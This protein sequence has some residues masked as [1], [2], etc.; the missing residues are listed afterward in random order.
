MTVGYYDNLR[1]AAALNGTIPTVNP[2]DDFEGSVVGGTVLFGGGT[3][4]FKGGAW[5]WGNRGKYSSAWDLAK[6]NAVN[7]RTPELLRKQGNIFTNPFTNKYYWQK[8]NDFE[9]R[10]VNQPNMKADYYTNV[11][12]DLSN[13]KKL[14][15]EG[16]LHGKELKTALNGINDKIYQAELN[17]LNDIKNGTIKETGF[18]SKINKYT[19]MNAANR[20]CLKAATKE[21][22]TATAKATRVAG[23]VGRGLIK[24]GGPAC[25]AIEMAFETPELIETYSKLGA[26]KGT[27]QLAKTTAVVGASTLGFVAGA[28]VG[29][30]LGAKIGTAI[31]ACFGGVGAPIGA[32]V[33]AIIGIGCGLLGSW[34]CRKGAQAAVGKSELEKAANMKTGS[35]TWEMTLNPKKAAKRCAELYAKA[36]TGLIEVNEETI[37]SL[38]KIVAQN[39][40]IQ[41][42]P[43]EF[44]AMV[45]QKIKEFQTKTA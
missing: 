38:Q 8:I 43:E 45:E 10:I 4:A 25:F 31:G 35:L 27:K 18:M 6:Q 14:A 40:F 17:V 19:G 13:V 16:K 3:A 7:A 30:I 37:A 11:K 12:T 44:K 33:G 28:K 26:G 9:S 42:K 21:G 24:G 36:K 29:G 39:K 34:L 22:A 1:I 15:S 41:K 32:A 5:L 23:R 20:V 2:I